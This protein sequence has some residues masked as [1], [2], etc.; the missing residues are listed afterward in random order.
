MTDVAKE[1]KAASTALKKMLLDYDTCL[2]VFYCLQDIPRR[3]DPSGDIYEDNIIEK[4]GA[5]GVDFNPAEWSDE[6]PTNGANEADWLIEQHKN[7]CTS[8]EAEFL[9][10]LAM[11]ALT[12]ETS[13]SQI[14]G[15]VE[16]IKGTDDAYHELLEKLR[17]R[18][19]PK[20]PWDGYWSDTKMKYI[21]TG[22]YKNVERPIDYAPSWWRKF[23]SKTLSTAKYL[24]HLEEHDYEED[25][26]EAL[27]FVPD[28]ELNR[29]RREINRW[30]RDHNVGKSRLA[31]L[32]KRGNIFGLKDGPQTKQRVKELINSGIIEN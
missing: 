18:R 25:F 31:K 14:Q 24:E 26:R 19:Q 16:L 10:D 17:N 23:R 11:V 1:I 15:I 20:T 30:L 27:W 6:Q 9:N 4:V 13:N 5:V 28:S 32:P 8:V 21:G 7:A 2:A 29:C 12:Q 3:L 22:S